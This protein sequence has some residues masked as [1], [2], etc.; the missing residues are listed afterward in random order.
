[1]ILVNDGQFQIEWSKGMTV[2]SLL[3]VCKLTYP[4]L[5]VAVNEQVVPR[6]AYGT[7]LLA[8]GDSVKARHLVSGG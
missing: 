3:Q 8:D 1:M 2:Q 7:H 6:E 4:I 5:L